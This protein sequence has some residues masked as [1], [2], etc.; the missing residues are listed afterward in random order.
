MRPRIGVTTAI[1][2]DGGWLGMD[3]HSAYCTYIGWIERCGGLPLLLP[4]LDPSAA[5]DCLAS[6]D[7]LLFTGGYDIHPSY[8]EA[9]PEKHLGR[10]DLK[11]DRWELPLAQA[12]LASD[13]PLLGICRGIQLLNVAAG[14][15]LR[16]DLVHDPSATIQ[17]RM[18][19]VG[20]D[21]RHHRVETA[22]DS[23][24]RRLLGESAWV[25]SAHH[26][27]VD[28]VGAG[29]RVTA[30]ATDQVVEAIEGDG[31]RYL[32][33]LQWHPELMEAGDPATTALFES[34]VAACKARLD[35]GRLGS[36]LA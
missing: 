22:P 21:P 20:G 14:G 7:G 31:E 10:V 30:R 29:L 19:V 16:Q 23:L 6:L 17:H 36:H 4:N 15:S 2:R 11:R 24:L 3:R 9:E 5:D 28:R 1:E 35:A 12:A 13:L 34:F 32:L 27:A 26:Q 8:F 18:D 25:S 33:G